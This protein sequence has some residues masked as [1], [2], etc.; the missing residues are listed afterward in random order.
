[1]ERRFVVYHDVAQ[2]QKREAKPCGD[3]IWAERV[4]W[5]SGQVETE[6]GTQNQ[7]T[8]RVIRDLQMSE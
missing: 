8:E 2:A 4:G 6:L 1:M 7:E 3:P 5:H